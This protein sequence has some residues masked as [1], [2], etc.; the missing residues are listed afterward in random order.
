MMVVNDRNHSEMDLKFHAKCSI[1]FINMFI[2][3]NLLATFDPAM[4]ICTAR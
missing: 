1:Q 4:F 2:I 3:G